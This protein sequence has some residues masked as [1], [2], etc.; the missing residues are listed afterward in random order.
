MIYDK[1]LEPMLHI[2]YNSFNLMI[3]FDETKPLNEFGCH[4]QHRNVYSQKQIIIGISGLTCDAELSG[5]IAQ[6]LC[7]Y[8]MTDV[9]KN[10]GKPYYLDEEKE[11]FAKISEK[12]REKYGQGVER[13][14]IGLINTLVGNGDLTLG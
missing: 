13:Y 12:C 8:T 1:T 2:I 10:S 5:R 7:N 6:K 4:V 14:L 3:R 11:K 9:F